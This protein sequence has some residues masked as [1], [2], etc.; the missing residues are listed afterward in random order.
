MPKTGQGDISKDILSGITITVVIFAVSVYMPII[1]F[2]SALLI[3][4]P[5]LFYR[6]KLGRT[7]GAIIPVLTII[8]MVAVLRGIS[9]D[10]LFFFELLLLGFI[11]SELFELDL[12]VEKTLLYACSSV[13]CTGIVCLLFYSKIAKIGI[14]ALVSEYVAKNLE[15][16]LALYKDIGVSKETIRMISASL[17]NIQYVLI[18]IIPAIVIASTFFVSW[19]CLLLSKP[20]LKRR[21]LFY[22]DFGA[23]NLWKAPEPLVWGLI[24]SG[25]L[26]IL[27]YTAFKIIG[28]NGLLILMTIYFFHGMAIVSFYFERKQFPRILRFFLYSLIALQQVVLLIVIGLG[29]FDM[30]LNF[31][32]IELKEDN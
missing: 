31:R 5:T 23:L 13:L 30:W 11:M 21:D 6:S 19:I 24:G 12:S 25:V 27:P 16:T 9:I 26:L 1:G 4:L 22:P 8:L 28:L 17:E 15:L 2:V 10:I 14:I 32:K 3:P 7:T 18:R 20:M 29:I